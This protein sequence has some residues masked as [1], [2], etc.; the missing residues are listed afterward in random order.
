[1]EGGAG[2]WVQYDEYYTLQ[3]HNTHETSPYTQQNCGARFT[4]AAIVVAARPH[5]NG[6]LIMESVYNLSPIFSIPL[7]SYVYRG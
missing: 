1:M 7:A 4:D 3:A 2:E 6:T 5:V